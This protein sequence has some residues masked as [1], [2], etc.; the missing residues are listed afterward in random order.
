[1]AERGED[2]TI[3]AE[4]LN[5]ALRLVRIFQH[6]YRLNFAPGIIVS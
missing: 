4:L 1:M 6:L 5:S 2:A 3:A